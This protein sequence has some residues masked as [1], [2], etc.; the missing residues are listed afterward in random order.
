M[1]F[2]EVEAKHICLMHYTDDLISRY[3]SHSWS[4]DVC[5]PEKNSVCIAQI[6]QSG[7]LPTIHGCQQLLQLIY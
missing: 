7:W 5:G 3:L 4:V 6:R 2:A 1:Q